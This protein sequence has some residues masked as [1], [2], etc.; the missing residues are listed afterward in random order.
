MKAI[1]LAAGYATRMYPL[2][3][4]RP[5]ALLTLNGRAIIDYIV[6]QING[7]SAA[8]EIIVV[9]NHKFYENFRVWTKDVRSKIPISLLND[10]STDEN[11]RLGA[12]GDIIFTLN[13]KKIDDDLLIIAGDNYSTYPLIE[14]YGL[15]T[16]KQSD[17]ICAKKLAD[18]NLLKRFAVAELDSSGRV[19]NLVEKP[20][21]PQSDYGVFATYFYKKETLP[22][23]AEYKKSGQNTDA[24][25]YFI[26]W[27]HKKK[28]IYAYIMNG[29]CYDIGTIEAY[30]EMKKLLGDTD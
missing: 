2:T 23:F 14:Q 26:E 19:V 5:K 22:L 17:I 15:F 7:L 27:L 9:T 13:E 3:L 25:G 18:R 1:I 6:E 12:I 28:D 24:P 10:G 4:N 11:N 20:D 8:D 21:N 16:E 30:D 29:D